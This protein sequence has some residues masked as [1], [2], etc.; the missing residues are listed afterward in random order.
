MSTP[1]SLKKILASGE[2]VVAPGVFDMF[3]ARIADQ[4]DFK[5][6]YMSGYGIS[7][8]YLGVADAGLISY[9]EMV[10]RAAVIAEG[11]SKPLIADA[12][13]GFG[14]LINLRRT[15]R[16]Y[17]AVGVQAIQFEDQVSPKKCGHTPARQVIPIAE[18]L[19]K[20]E[21]AVEARRSSETLIIARTDARSELGLDEAIRRG[22]AYA[23][24]GADII[25]IESPES[26]DEFRRIG[27]EV[28]GWLMANMVPTGL[29]PELCSDTLGEWGFNIVIYP[30]L[31]MAVASA[32][33]GAGYR[34]LQSKGTTIGLDI[35]AY[36]MDQL[37]DL[38][39]FPE[40]WEFERRHVMIQ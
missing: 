39:G 30:A 15:I 17:E 22:N 35:P 28:D 7:G 14:G 24:A 21:V 19:K 1:A 25:F 13:T 2:L 29:S 34:F 8:S 9:T 4:L 6:L 5:A 40:I 23:K 27:A 12:D 36:S 3:S 10:G 20:I 31:G 18:M 11:I 33:L 38:M 32:A 16:G 37:H 26:E